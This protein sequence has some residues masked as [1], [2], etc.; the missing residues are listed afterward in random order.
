MTANL[1]NH[2]VPA[3]KQ[4]APD[5]G[6]YVNEAD[7]SNPEWKHDYFGA[8]YDKLLEVKNKYDP[9]GVFWC[10]PCVGWDQWEIQN[11]PT[12][13]DVLEWGIGQGAG[14]LCQKA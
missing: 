3:L 7:P 4:L 13:E 8:N 9:E 11:G 10:K 14:R 2:A 1:R 6:A 5:S 12:D